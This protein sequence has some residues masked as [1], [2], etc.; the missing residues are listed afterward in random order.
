MRRSFA[1]FIL[2]FVS[3]SIF[4]Q[5]GFRFEPEN[6]KKTV[7]PFELINNLIFIPVRVNGV[8]LTFL[9]D[10]GVAQTIL[11]SLDEEEVNFQNIDK[12]KLK[13]LGSTASIE[14]LR[15][16]ANRVEFPGL[17]DDNHE[18][19]IVLDQDFNFSSSIGIPV[20]GIIGYDFFKNYAVEISYDSRRIVV[21]NKVSSKKLKRHFRENEIMVENEKPY[22]VVQLSEEQQ[23]LP[24]KV[25]LDT[26]S[27][28]AIWLFPDRSTQIK[29]PDENFDDFLGRS[30]S[31]DVQ[32]KRARMK[33][34]DFL[35]FR[36]NNPL[37]AFPDSLIT[38]DIAMV[39]DRV[40]SIG[41]EIFRRFDV[42][43]DYPHQKIYLRRNN[44]FDQPFQYNMSG[45]EIHHEG[46]T[47]IKETVDMQ[48]VLESS[49][50]DI[51]GEKLPSTFTYKFALKPIYAV[52]NVRK[53]SPGE[54]CGLHKGDI[55]LTIN[56]RNGY[57]Y[58]LQEINNLLKSEEG[59]RITMEVQR[60]GKV[61]KV[62]FTLKKVI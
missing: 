20:N 46:M 9:L 35:S 39:E 42:V 54:L 61:L 27:S 32:G 6:R 10:T 58:T 40:G 22:A 33:T 18:I 2:L 44:E 31:G 38:K 3:A 7:I 59:R 50:Y 28:D 13:G 16:T 49:S 56:N 34:L 1:L 43:F 37:V 11:F 53:D 23:N 19:F 60:D 5:A 15:S 57:R 30:F 29:V 51:N 26:G 55:I 25:L 62:E 24:A 4:A 45:I 8:D 14:G 47:W 48:P 21:Y 36:F 17:L 52:S 12:I 41:G